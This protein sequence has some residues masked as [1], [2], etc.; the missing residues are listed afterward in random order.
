MPWGM[1]SVEDDIRLVR[2]LIQWADSNANQLA[3]S[4]GVANTTINR[5]AN[6]SAKGRLHRDTLRKLREK[7]PDF[8]GFEVDADLPAG[9]DNPEYLA[10]D[11]LPSYAGMGGGGS[12]EG[13]LS[14]ALVPRSLVEDELRAKPSDLLL[15]EARGESMQPDFQ[16]GDQILIDKRDRN[17]AQPG[18]FALWDG[19]AYV[20]KMIERIPLEG[21]RIRIFSANARFTSYE[22]DAEQVQ[23]MGR[24]VWFGRRL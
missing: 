1:S 12:G 23:I 16:H 20:I 11:V 17:P 13:D 4:I 9:Y 7:Y 15:I 22:A 8:P 6:G 24:P 3:K 5:F 21:G 10:I 2:D 14:Q 18:T 19:D